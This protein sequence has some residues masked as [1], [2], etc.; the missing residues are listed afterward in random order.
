MGTSVVLLLSDSGGLKTKSSI[1]LGPNLLRREPLHQ[2]S[3][4]GARTPAHLRDFTF[5]AFVLQ[6]REFLT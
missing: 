6:K 3:A 2:Q 1:A 4:K 5:R